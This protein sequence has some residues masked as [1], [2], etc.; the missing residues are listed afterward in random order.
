MKSKMRILLDAI[1]KDDFS[2]VEKLAESNADGE[3]AGPHAL[4]GGLGAV[5][6]RDDALG[7]HVAQTDTQYLFKNIAAR[8]PSLPINYF[9][10]LFLCKLV[11][12]VYLI[13]AQ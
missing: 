9:D 6:L 10:R 5:H 2:K 13:L 1:A 4:Y 12:N 11:R 8:L 3:Q 7:P